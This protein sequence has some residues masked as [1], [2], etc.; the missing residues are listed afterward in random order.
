MVFRFTRNAAKKLKLPAL[1]TVKPSGELF[2]E[3]FVNVFYTRQRYKY[4]ITTN[5]ATLYS[6]IIH[7]KGVVDDAIL[8][9][10]FFSMLETLLKDNECEFVHKRFIEPNKN[11]MTL[12]YTNNR[13]ILASMNDLIINAKYALDHDG[14][15]PLDASKD[16]NEMPMGFINMQSPDRYIKKIRILNEG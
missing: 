8:F 4:F 11:G 2:Q 1:T 16:I 13:S 12:S 15:S 9:G 3:W 7:G 5:A 14:L 10:D 6:V